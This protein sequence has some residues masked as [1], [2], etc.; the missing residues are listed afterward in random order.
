MDVAVFRRSRP[1]GGHLRTRRR[2]TPF[3]NWRPR[4]ACTAARRGLPPAATASRSCDS[5]QRSLVGAARRPGKE[6]DEREAARSVRRCGHHVARTTSRLGWRSS[7]C[8]RCS[9]AARRAPG[10]C[11]ADGQSLRNLTGMGLV[12]Q[13]FHERDLAKLGGRLASATP[14]TRP[15]AR[16]R[17]ENAQPIVVASACTASA[18]LG[19]LA[20]GAQRQPGQ[21]RRGA[22]EVEA[23]RRRARAR[24]PTPS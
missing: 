9:T 6:P 8:M 2:S 7:P 14:A 3:S 16:S 13:V 5:A 23:L 17:A 12:S 1:R 24:R 22:G 4:T 19:S 20:P 21:R 18:S 15:P 11:T 10:I